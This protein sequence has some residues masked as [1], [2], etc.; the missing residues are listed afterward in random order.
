[1]KIKSYYILALVMFLFLGCSDH[2]EPINIYPQ[3]ISFVH[4]DGS[5]ISESECISPNVKYAIKIETN[6]VDINRPFRVDYSVNGVVYTMTF[7]LNISEI[8]PITLVNGTNTAQIIGSNHTTVL[9]YVDQG[10]F[11]LVE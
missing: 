7:A 4:A 8:N 5:K 10:D 6:H 11:Q 3:S 1:M 9:N 2:E